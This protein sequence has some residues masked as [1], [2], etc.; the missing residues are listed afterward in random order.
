MD[1]Q[2]Q[3]ILPGFAHLLPKETANILAEKEEVKAQAEWPSFMHSWKEPFIG[4]SWEDYQRDYYNN[5]RSNWFETRLTQQLR[6]SYITDGDN[7]RQV[8]I[9]YNATAVPAAPAPF[10]PPGWMYERREIFPDIPPTGY[11]VIDDYSQ[12]RPFT[13]EEIDRVQEMYRRV[14]NEH[15]NR[16]QEE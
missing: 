2:I 3:L 7:F 16:D 13:Q 14:Q 8:Y 1:K 10:K 4:Y 9:S 11:T 15:Y 6:S 12:P 5:L